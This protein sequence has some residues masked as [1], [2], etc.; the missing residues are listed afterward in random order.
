MFILDINIYYLINKKGQV[1]KMVDDNKIA[2]H[3]GKSRWKKFVN[4]NEHSIGIELVNR[5][6]DFGYQK[7]SKIQI[8]SLIKL[9][10]R[11]KKKYSLFKI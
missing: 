8:T 5:G 11:L 10:K 2:W 7:F 3:A 9:C 1:V 6:R 4:L